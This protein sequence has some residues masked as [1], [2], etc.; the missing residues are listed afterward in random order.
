MYPLCICLPCVSV[1]YVRL[2]MCVFELWALLSDSNKFD[3]IDLTIQYEDLDHC[4]DG[5]Q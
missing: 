5:R 1:C 3:M 2:R 4:D